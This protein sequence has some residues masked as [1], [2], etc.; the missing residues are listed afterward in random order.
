MDFKYAFTRALRGN[1]VAHITR[2]HRKKDG[3]MIR[4]G[5]MFV[6]KGF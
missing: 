5:V 6:K 1:K 2:I 3:E 4:S